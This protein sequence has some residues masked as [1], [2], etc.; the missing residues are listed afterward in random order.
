VRKKNPFKGGPVSQTEME[1][2]LQELNKAVPEA[3]KNQAFDKSPRG[4]LARLHFELCE[5]A[6]LL[7]EKKNHDYANEKDPFANFR[8]FGV[9]G[10]AVRMGDKLSRLTSFLQNGELSVDESL[11]DTV[12]DLINYSVIFLAMVYEVQQPK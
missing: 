2:M 9:L 11:R 10:V 12:L 5:E 8:M 7:M 3:M 4:Q 6:R 1:T